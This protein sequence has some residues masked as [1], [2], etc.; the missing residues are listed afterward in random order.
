MEMS[1]VQSCKRYCCQNSTESV[2][3]D[4]TNSVKLCLAS[5][6]SANNN[7]EESNNFTGGYILIAIV[8]STFVLIFIGFCICKRYRAQQAVLNNINNP[9]QDPNTG[10]PPTCVDLNAFDINTEGPYFVNSNDSCAI[11]LDKNVNLRTHC[12]HFYHGKCL[13]AWLKKKINNPCPLCMGINYN[14]VKVYCQECHS[15]DMLVNIMPQTNE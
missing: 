2:N 12:N 3:S 10:L 4:K 15:G 14:P 7:I 13:I 11:C 1:T 8:G 6:A 9:S 5:A